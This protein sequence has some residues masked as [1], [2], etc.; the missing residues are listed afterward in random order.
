MSVESPNPARSRRSRSSLKQPKP[1]LLKK[2]P[3]FHLFLALAAMTLVSLAVSA[4]MSSPPSSRLTVKKAEAAPAEPGT[5]REF[6][7]ETR[8][9]SVVPQI[10]K[11]SNEELEIRRNL[12]ETEFEAGHYGEAERIY[13]ELLD[14][15]QR[16]TLTAYQIFTCMVMQGKRDEARS[17]LAGTPNIHSCPAGQYADATIYFVDGNPEKAL[18]L[19]KEARTSYPRLSL[20]YDPTLRTLGYLP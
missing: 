9:M 15:T 6:S 18:R 4:L 13:R 14:N 16:K 20:L 19:L 3:W 5:G 8:K 2:V 17:F 12:A 1:S 7:L 11:V 10:P